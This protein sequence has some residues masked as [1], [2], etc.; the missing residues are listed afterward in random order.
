MKQLSTYY[1]MTKK[2]SALTYLSLHILSF[3]LILLSATI[4]QSILAV[5]YVGII[6]YYLKDSSQV[7]TQILVKQVL[8]R[9]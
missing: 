6:L 7:L 8:D 1:R 5:V 4:R 9:K 2:G 3:F